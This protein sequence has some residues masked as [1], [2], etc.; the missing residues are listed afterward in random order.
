MYITNEIEI[1]HTPLPVVCLLPETDTEYP[2]TEANVLELVCQ[3]GR[4]NQI[5]TN[6]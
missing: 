1:S 3:A 4:L 6:K 2:Q 5:L